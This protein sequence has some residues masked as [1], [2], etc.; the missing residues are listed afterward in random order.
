[1]KLFDQSRVLATLFVASLG[2]S[3]AAHADSVER[4][5]SFDVHNP[6]AFVTALDEFRGSGI[7]DGT[8]AS[9]WAA[10]FD[11][12]NPTSHVL[13]ISYDDY[14]ELQRVDDRVR[15]SREWVDYLNAIRDTNDLMALG[16]GIERYARGSGWHNHGAAMVFN[17]TVRD[18]R[19]YAPAFAEL[20][21]SM[22]NPG[23][24]RLIEIRAGGEGATHLA[25]ITAPD[26]VTL[27]TFMDELLG[28]EAYADFVEEVGDIRTINTTSIYRR[29]K[30]W[31]E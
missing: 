4:Y 9:L 6:A 21:E 13:A 15:P 10:T 1:M 8:E 11:G 12:S 17:M 29:V 2:L 19:T 25:I 20:V 3:A 28:S 22:D 26:F 27:N 18:P 31:G 14:A 24:S 5:V 30:T 23:S 16:M 7:M